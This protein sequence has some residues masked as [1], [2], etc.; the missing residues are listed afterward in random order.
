MPVQLNVQLGVYWGHLETLAYCT[1]D[2]ITQGKER[3]G[4]LFES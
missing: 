1:D 4:M 2:I 3:I